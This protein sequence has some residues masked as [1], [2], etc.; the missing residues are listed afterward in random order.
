MQNDTQHLEFLISQ[1]VD[2]TLDAVARKTIEQQLLTDPVA[3]GLYRAQRETQ[4]VLDDFGS[5]IPLIDWQNFDQTLAARLERETQ[6]VPQVSSFRRW[7][8]P[9]AIAAALLIAVGTGYWFHAMQGPMRVSP[10]QGS[11]PIARIE[12]RHSVTLDAPQRNVASSSEV[13]VLEGPD[14]QPQS[15]GRVAVYPPDEDVKPDV[16]N[17]FAPRHAGLPLQPGAVQATNTTRPDDRLD[18]DRELQ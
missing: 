11:A 15:R 17:I 6:D 3:Q 9:L 1:Y 8:R 7:A 10:N 2:G 4:D 14:A 12:P 13:R 5:R 16:P 18:G